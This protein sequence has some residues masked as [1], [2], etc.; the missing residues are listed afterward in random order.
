MQGKRARWQGH[1]EAWGSSGLSQSAY[2]LQHGLSPASFGYWRRRLAAAAVG[3]RV[4]VLPIKVSAPMTAEPQVQV[5]LP[6]G[7]VLSLP[8]P[9]DAVG[10][11]TLLRSLCA[12]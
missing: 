7:L 2:C 6:N 5:R 12:C 4:G 9:A 8:L 11:Q 3:P 1:V 10:M